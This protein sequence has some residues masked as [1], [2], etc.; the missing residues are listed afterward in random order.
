MIQKPSKP[1]HLPSSYRPIS[2]LPLLGKVLEKLLLR[3]IY[4]IID[5]LKIIPDHQFGFRAKHST[6]QQCHRVVDTIASTLEQKQYCSA[7]FLDEAQAFDRVW[8]AGLL[9]KLKNILPLTYYRILRSY[10]SNRFFKVSQGSA[11]SSLRS[12]KAGVP[13]GSILAPLLYSVYSAD[14]PL[15]PHTILS[16]FADD[17]AILS[18]HPNPVLAS[19]HL[20]EHLNSL[21]SWFRKWKMKINTQ[22]SV[23]ITFTLCRSTCPPVTLNLVPLPV[24]DSVKY[25]GLYI[26]KKLTWNP[27]TRLKRQELNRKYK[28]LLRLL[29]HRSTLS[30]NN[31]LL[32]Y[33]SIIKPT[34]TYGIELWGSAKP[35]NI[36]RIQTLQ[37]IILRKIT[38][39]PF[40][41]TNYTLHKD[42]HVPF[43]RNYAVTAYNKFHEKLQPH[44]NP[45][46]QILATPDLPD[47]TTRRLKRTWPRDLINARS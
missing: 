14:I 21:Q 4:P 10:L 41:V 1:T 34:W 22:K 25:L 18:K 40:Y 11:L 43:V 20:Q 9:W 6:T 38:N 45:L 15:H 7:A 26:D 30:L 24:A 31:K 33:N 32:I 19:S 35:S 29:D 39:A 12:I 13:Q 16:T 42:L 8:H 27:H 44:P 5:S 46:V 23:H 17:K 47:V 28:M 2:L 36:H 3:R 37:S